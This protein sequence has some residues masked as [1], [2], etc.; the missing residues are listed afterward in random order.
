MRWAGSN[1]IYPHAP[2]YYSAIVSRYSR[3][4]G[5]AE[6]IGYFSFS[7]HLISGLIFEPHQRA[8]VISCFYGFPVG[9]E[10]YWSRQTGRQACIISKEKEKVRNRTS[11]SFVRR[12][13][14]FR[15][16]GIHTRLSQLWRGI[17]PTFCELGFRIQG[18]W[19]W[20]CSEQIYV[21]GNIQS[22]N[23]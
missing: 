22:H 9:R 17:H 6:E 11:G 20:G 2:L 14:R 1:E 23:W 13:R 15:F 4:T 5:D 19:W 18:G 12:R 10:L 3:F 8:P 16:W 7:R 21:L